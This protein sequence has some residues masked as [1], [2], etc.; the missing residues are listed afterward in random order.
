MS[1][2]VVSKK[3]AD[4][5]PADI[6]FGDAARSTLL[7][8]LQKMMENA[9]GTRSGLLRKEPTP[10]EVMA[11]HDM[12]VGSR[13]LRAALSVFARAFSKDDWRD[14]ESDLGDITDA[15]AAVR[16]LDVQRE[17]LATL[18]ASLPDNEAYGV[19][20]LRER[21]ANRR[22]RERKILIKALDRLKKNRLEKRFIKALERGPA[23]EG[24]KA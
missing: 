11:L 8:A 17:T 19:E 10:D 6:G 5:L 16:D 22:D 21:L 7:P 3:A 24:A 20:R 18:A 12:R 2:D 4:P 9:K 23:S 13:R 1:Q 15:L 14:I